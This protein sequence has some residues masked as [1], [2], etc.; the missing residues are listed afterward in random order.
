M[1][2]HDHLSSERL[3]IKH[4][5]FTIISHSTFKDVKKASIISCSV[6]R[7]RAQN[8]RSILHVKHECREMENYSSDTL[9][10]ISREKCGISHTS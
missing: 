5:Y 6:L 2:W 4:L 7:S 10:N 1:F 3:Q 8:K 9:E